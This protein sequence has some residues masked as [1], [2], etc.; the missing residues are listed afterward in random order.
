MVP[1]Q[2]S[3]GLVS[4]RPGGGCAWGLLSQPSG[5]GWD[6]GLN[7]E[8]VWGSACGGGSVM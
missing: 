8:E 6:S 2:T 3:I 5:L 7:H 4:L 1:E